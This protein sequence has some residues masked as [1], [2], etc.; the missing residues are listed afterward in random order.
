M[1]HACVAEAGTNDTEKA[2]CDAELEKQM[3]FDDDVTEDKKTVL[4]RYRA[5]KLGEASAC[6]GDAKDC[7]AAAKAKAEESGMK[8]REYRQVQRV[9]SVNT[10]AKVFADC[11]E[12]GNEDVDCD[13]QAKEEYI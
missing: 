2:E 9:A 3:T 4:T 5:D 8:P 10:A 6:E 11:K 7:R 13:A 12:A 1:H